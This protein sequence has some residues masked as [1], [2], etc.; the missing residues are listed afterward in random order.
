MLLHIQQFVVVNLTNPRNHFYLRYSICIYCSDILH[1]S[2]KH[3]DSAYFTLISL[4]Y[5][6]LK[7]IKTIL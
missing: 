3:A 4:I 7:F 2:V 5:L 6:V 1:N